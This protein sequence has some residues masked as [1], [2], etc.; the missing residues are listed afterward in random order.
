MFQLVKAFI[1]LVL[2]LGQIPIQ[3]GVLLDEK[4]LITFA[5][6]AGLSFEELRILE[7]KQ[8]DIF[9]PFS[10][11]DVHTAVYWLKLDSAMVSGYDQ[12]LLSSYF[13]QVKVFYPGHVEPY[14]STGRFVEF[15]DRGYAKEF[16]DLA[17]D[18][19]PQGGTVYI[20]LISRQ[21]YTRYL[22]TISNLELIRS[23]RLHD[24]I[25]IIKT[26]T[27]LLIGMEFIILMINCVLF[28]LRPNFIVFSYIC[29]IF[30]SILD[31]INHNH[32]MAGLLNISAITSHYLEIIVSVVI[33]YSH[34][35]FTALYLQARKYAK[36]LHY[37]LVLPIYP[38]VLILLWFGSES[39]FPPVGGIYFLLVQAICVLL[40]I[41]VWNKKGQ[42]AKVY[43][44]AYSLPILMA[45]VTVLALNGFLPR[46]Y[47]T[48]K[49]VYL[50]L[51]L[52]DILF[53]ID[54]IRRYFNLQNESQQRSIE[55]QRLINE[56]QQLEKL[57][58]AKVAFFN[59]ITHEWR[60][61][62]TLLLSPLE[63][64]LKSKKMPKELKSDLSL[65]LKNGKYLLQLVNEMLDISKLD[66]EN[67]KIT[68]LPTDVVQVLNNIRET[69]QPYAKEKG[70]TISIAYLKDSIIAHLD[71]DKF[72]K[73]II[74]LLSNAIKY[75]HKPGNIH[76]QVREHGNDLEIKVI[77][78]SRGISEQDLPR[79]FD[80]YYTSSDG[81]DVEGT[82]IGLSIVEELMRAH[83]G[84]VNCT[85]ELHKGSIFTLYFPEALNY[86]GHHE[87]S[88]QTDY[89]DDSKPKILIVEDH[90]EL[91]T[92]LKKAFQ[93]YAVFE[94]S[95][96]QQA[97][98]MLQ[99]G[100]VP[101]LIL[102]D[103]VM[104]EMGGYDLAVQLKADPK[105][106]MI[107]I[108]FL[109]ARTLNSDK[110]KVLNLGVNDYI[111]KPFDLEELKL[112]I[113]N[114]LKIGQKRQEFSKTGIPDLTFEKQNSFKEELDDYILKNLHNVNLSNTDLAYHFNLSERNLFRRVKLVTGQPPAS[115][116]R[117]IRLQKSRLILE[118]DNE[119]TISDI[120]RECGIEN[121]AYF[122]QLFKKRFGKAPSD[123]FQNKVSP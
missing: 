55:M 24:R 112:R 69:F 78:E 50:G 8:P 91:R 75:R 45:I 111:I 29:L 3:A 48:T 70:Q 19:K 6:T 100:L 52:R 84:S 117:E 81:A 18:L 21:G 108:I 43:V 12:I 122:S 32:I 28:G 83:E 37:L 86:N 94:A 16:Y 115:Y 60:T 10:G 58:Q 88:P 14:S 85:S 76:I 39:L 46:S 38:V 57:E 114:S 118:A 97:L 2:L 96:G 54:L 68:R 66:Q 61:P 44:F 56:K 110:L 89:T 20:Q 23:E 35:V 17:V 123:M 67:L 65:S 92:Y 113:D 99:K 51:I 121:I 109:T 87:T 47:F 4:K 106:N 103:Y 80:R 93:N 27:I 59:N 101:S 120:A 33:V 53:T 64:S 25:D 73:I 15:N 7:G 102:T 26:V 5:D 116:I 71:Q 42:H 1:C 95:N 11:M 31:T 30:I 40:I 82:G 79:I 49:A 98:S 62:L 107:P 41:K 104:P 13:E 63:N 9:Q 105:W 90:Q 72:E 119:R 36:I 22:R 74:N 77:D 34:A